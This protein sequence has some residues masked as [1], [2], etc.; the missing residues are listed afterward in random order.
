MREVGRERKGK[1]SVGNGRSGLERGKGWEWSTVERNG[2]LVPPSK[3]S[4][5]ATSGTHLLLAVFKLAHRFSSFVVTSG[6]GCKL[7]SVYNITG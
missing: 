5:C 6:S 2:D 4:R 7:S 1:R 3:Y